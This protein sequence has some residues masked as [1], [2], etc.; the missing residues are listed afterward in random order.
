MNVDAIRKTLRVKRPP[1]VTLAPQPGLAQSTVIVSVIQ[2]GTTVSYP[3]PWYPGMSVLNALEQALPSTPG[4]SS[5][6][7]NYFPQY[8]GYLVSAV[9]G[10]PAAG[11]AKSWTISL[12][13]AGPGSTM[14]RLPLFPNKILVCSG[15][16]VILAYD[17]SCGEAPS[18]H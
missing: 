3:V 8:G 13:P 17:Q 18:S 7:L 2:N 10:V 16:N 1:L 15:D 6:S 12:L 9:G 14:I 11:E 5:L 4:V